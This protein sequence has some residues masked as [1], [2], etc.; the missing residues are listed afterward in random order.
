MPRNS[1]QRQC[2]SGYAPPHKFIRNVLDV[3]IATGKLKHLAGPARRIVHLLFRQAAGLRV[4]WW[5]FTLVSNWRRKR[6]CVWFLVPW[7]CSS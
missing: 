2:R 4:N 3:G 7:P 6:T 1:R 5:R